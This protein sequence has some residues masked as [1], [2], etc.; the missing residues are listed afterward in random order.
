[1]I[2]PLVEAAVDHALVP[3]RR[4]EQIAQTIL[5]VCDAHSVPWRM[6]LDTD[7]KRQLHVAATEAVARLRDSA[8]RAEVESAAQRAIAPIVVSFEHEEAC[9]NMLRNIWHALPGGTLSECEQGKDAVRIALGSI[10]VGASVREMERARDLALQSIRAEIASRTDRDMRAGLLRHITFRFLGWSQELQKQA[11]HE[12]D[13][14]F[15]RHRAGTPQRDLEVVRDEIIERYKEM[16]RFLEA[17]RRLIND[18]LS[19]VRPYLDRLAVDWEFTQSLYSLTQEVSE[20][21]RPILEEELRGD[22]D[23]DDVERKVRRLVREH[24]DV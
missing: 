5:A 21:I 10:R 17:K 4:T 16:Q 14:S 1:V 9:S 22:E 3:W 23:L 13:S 2:R 24:L 15:A 8:S 20:A 19:K 12:I 11:L 6:K 7:W 18:G